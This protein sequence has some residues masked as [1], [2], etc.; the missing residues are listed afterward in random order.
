[1]ASAGDPRTALD[2]ALDDF[3]R[4][5]RESGRLAPRSQ[6]AYER[7]LKQFLAWCRNQSINSPGQVDALAVRQHL[8]ALARSGLDPRSIQRHLSA[9]RRFF[10][11]LTE[12]GRIRANPCDGLK[13]PRSRRR[14]PATL[15]PD[16]V[17]QLLEIEGEDPL[18]LRDRALLELCYSSGLR[19]SELAAARWRQIDMDQGMMRVIGKGNKER[20]VPVGRYALRALRQWRECA[21][22]LPAGD[23][24]FVFTGLNGRPLSVRAI[25]KRIALRA[26]LQGLDVPVHPHQLRHSFA[27]H[28]LESSGDLRA[29]QE[30]LGHANLSTTQIYTH[31]DFQHL[32]EVYDRAHPRAQKRRQRE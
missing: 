22:R 23:D 12:Q 30:L 4:A 3:L 18:D 27:S 5:I 10:R 17:R 26:R 28:L 31:L 25:Q 8:S 13:A 1:M 2:E 21:R 32:A 19:V 6:A 20:L 29:V 24:D 11:H 14:L 7:D 9:L 16:Q 15:D